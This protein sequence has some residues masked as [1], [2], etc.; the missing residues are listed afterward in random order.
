[1]FDTTDAF[2]AARSM[3]SSRVNRLTYVSVRVSNTRRFGIHTTASCSFSNCKCKSAAV[4]GLGCLKGPGPVPT[5]VLSPVGGPADAI[6]PVVV[7]GEARGGE[8]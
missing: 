5:P 8:I 4:R 2:C 7:F 1:M 6:D 3:E